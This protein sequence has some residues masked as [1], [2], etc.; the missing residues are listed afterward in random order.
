METLRR[1]M[2][3]VEK[4]ALLIVAVVGGMLAGMLHGYSARDGEVQNL[5]TQ[6]QAVSDARVTCEANYRHVRQ[7]LPPSGDYGKSEDAP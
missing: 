2:S 6:L 5:T 1:V 3:W 4:Q 7:Y